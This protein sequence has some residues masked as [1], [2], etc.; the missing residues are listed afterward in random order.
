MGIRFRKQN[1]DTFVVFEGA[2]RSEY[3]GR[4]WRMGGGWVRGWGESGHRLAIEIGKVAL[5]SPP[6]KFVEYVKV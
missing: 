4:G 2:E 6:R 1:I 5:W 3:D